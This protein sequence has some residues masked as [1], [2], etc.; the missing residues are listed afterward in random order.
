VSLYTFIIVIAII[1]YIEITRRRN[2][3][4]VTS[5]IRK[6][7]KE[8]KYQLDLL[9]KMFS[10]EENVE[11]TTTAAQVQVSRTLLERNEKP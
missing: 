8:M 10:R 7:K 9:G 5:E 1:V 6:V 3:K 4:K 2:N 11:T